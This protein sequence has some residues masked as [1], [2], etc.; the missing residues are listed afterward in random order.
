MKMSIFFVAVLA[1]LAS[2]ADAQI[3]TI[4]LT[5][6]TGTAT[7]YWQTIDILVSPVNGVEVIHDGTTGNLIVAGTALDTVSSRT[8]YQKTIKPGEIL[9][10]P[11]FANT[12]IFVK[13]SAN[14]ISYRIGTY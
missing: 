14:T 9:D 13:A 10:I 12:N 11:N 4:R 1:L 5:D 3:Q 8:R 6:S 7:V 2:V